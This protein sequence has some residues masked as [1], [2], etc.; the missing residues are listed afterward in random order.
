[1]WLEAVV[2]QEDLSTLVAELTPLTIRL[3]DDGRLLLS[4]PSDVSLVEDVGLRVVCKAQLHWSILG[5][6]VPVTLHSL[7]LLLKPAIARRDDHWAL[8]FS[9][10]IEHADLAGVPDVIDA[11]VTEL[12]NHELAAKR[13]ELSWG[14]SRTLSHVFDLP[15]TL[16]P[17][18]QLDVTA[19]RAQVKATRNAL[20]LAI[21]MQTHV[22]REGSRRGAP[23]KPAIRAAVVPV[24][25]PLWTRGAILGGLLVAALCGAFALGRA[26]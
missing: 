21:E 13:V 7:T 3:G 18:E 5:L 15:S 20:A 8:V 16:E 22:L 10:E 26:S 24:P 23:T 11:R 25:R 6:S 9:L 14:Y 4:E 2:L 19:G 17:P 12:V 1:M